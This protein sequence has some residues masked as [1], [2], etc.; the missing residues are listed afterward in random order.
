MP[1]E[2]TAFQELQ[3]ISEF[4]DNMADDGL[5]VC[6]TVDTEDG[7]MYRPTSLRTQDLVARYRPALSFAEPATASRV[8]LLMQCRLIT[9]RIATA[10][11]LAWRVLTRPAVKPLS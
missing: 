1:A 2:H 9:R 5:F 11:K 10:I 4:L 7:L 6:F 8:S 3:I